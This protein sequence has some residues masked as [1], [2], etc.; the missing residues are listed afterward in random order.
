MKLQWDLRSGR[1]GSSRL[2]LGQ[3]QSTARA[4]TGFVCHALVRTVNAEHQDKPP[5]PPAPQAGRSVEDNGRCGGG[6]VDGGGVPGEALADR[7]QRAD[8]LPHWKKIKGD[9]GVGGR[10]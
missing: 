2:D 7:L 10:R 1:G 8:Q 4:S 3:Y 5:Q 6:R 9:E